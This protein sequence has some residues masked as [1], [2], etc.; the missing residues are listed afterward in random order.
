LSGVVLVVRLQ[1]LGIGDAGGD[2]AHDGNTVDDGN[3]VH[4]NNTVHGG[5]T[6]DGG[7]TVYDGNTVHDRIDDRAYLHYQ[8]YQHDQHYQQG[9]HGLDQAVVEQAICAHERAFAFVGT[10]KSTFSLAIHFARRQRMQRELRLQH[11]LQLRLQHQQRREASEETMASNDAAVDAALD[12]TADVEKPSA[13]T[14]TATAVEEA[15]TNTATATAV[16]EA[17]ANTATPTAAGSGRMDWTKAEV[18]ATAAWLASSYS[19]ALGLPATPLD[20]QRPQQQQQPLQ[21]LPLCASPEEASQCEAWFDRPAHLRWAR[22]RRKQAAEK[23]RANNSSRSDGS[24]SS[25]GGSRSSGG[26]GRDSGV[27]GTESRGY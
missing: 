18:D 8:Q 20:K 2:K 27:V 5:N 4:D 14:A 22:R 24:S 21:L 25:M 10:A 17:S 19:L 1:L 3:T 16:E 6:V 23:V 7:N 26:S 11:Q 12:G 9:M 13:N 15:S